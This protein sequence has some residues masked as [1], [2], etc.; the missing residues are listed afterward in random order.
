[1]KS[2]IRQSKH[3]Q[4]TAQSTQHTTLPLPGGEENG[5]SCSYL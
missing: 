2:D 3:P 5:V 4:D 1:M